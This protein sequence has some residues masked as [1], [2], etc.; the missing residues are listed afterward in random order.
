ML[1]S[2]LRRFPGGI[3]WYSMIWR[4]TRHILSYFGDGGVTVASARI[5]AAASA[6]ASSPAQ[7]HSVCG[8][9]LCCGTTVNNNGVCVIWKALCPYILDSRLGLWISLEH[10]FTCVSTTIQAKRRSSAVHLLARWEHERTTARWSRAQQPGGPF[11]IPT[12]GIH[13]KLRRLLTWV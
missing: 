10:T 9:K 1:M 6:E 12:A 2:G 4:P 11:V 13:Y 7:L 8:D 3:V 5:I